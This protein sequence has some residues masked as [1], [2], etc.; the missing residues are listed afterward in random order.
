MEKTFNYVLENEIIY[1][2]LDRENPFKEK[3][4]NF[5]DEIS[6]YLIVNNDSIITWIGMVLSNVDFYSKNRVTPIAVIDIYDWNEILLFSGMVN[7][8]ISKVEPKYLFEM[9]Y[10]GEHNK[11]EFDL[12]KNGKHCHFK[13]K[14]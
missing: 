1:N 9:F 8:S 13:L 11:K 7:Y 10:F 3:L 14:S 2:P 6:K 5:I 4:I 12:F